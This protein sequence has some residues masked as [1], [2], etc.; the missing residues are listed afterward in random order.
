[1]RQLHPRETL[2]LKTAFRLLCDQVGGVDAAAM[3]LSYPK[4]HLSDAA[5]PH[6]PDRS[7]RVDHVAELE[8]L[9]GEPLVTATLARLAGHE[10]R[11][12]EDALAGCARGSLLAV[13][14]EAGGALR[15]VAEAM[16]DGAIC[17]AE[18]A[19]LAAQ[20]DSLARAVSAAQSALA[21]EGRK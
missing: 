3:A 15:Q 18:R 14:A 13:V 7:P 21:A 9:G 12:R 5:S 19:A 20:L 4:S 16:A 1:M 17:G 2:A 6:H 10:L 8:A 11:P